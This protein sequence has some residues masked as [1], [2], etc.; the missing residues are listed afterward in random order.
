MPA[1]DDNRRTASLIAEPERTAIPHI[2]MARAVP[3][4]SW[5]Q[6]P[7]TFG[8][9]PYHITRRLFLNPH[10]VYGDCYDGGAIVHP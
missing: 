6:V 9:T 1:H 2:A 7:L 4:C 5:V 10:S 8:I 3:D